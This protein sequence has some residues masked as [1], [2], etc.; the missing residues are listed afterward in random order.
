MADE[1]SSSTA[2]HAFSILLQA[3]Q[4]AAAIGILVI[5]ALL[6]VQIKK[7]TD[8]NFV[9]SVQSPEQFPVRI[10]QNSFGTGSLDPFYVVAVTQN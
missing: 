1:K 9:L 8:P 4:A 3:V 10:G 2:Y 7:L 6:L 5:L